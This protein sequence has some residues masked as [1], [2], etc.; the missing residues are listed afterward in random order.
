[1]PTIEKPVELAQALEKLAALQIELQSAVEAVS[2][3]NVTIETLT[4]ENADLKNSVTEKENEFT[5][6]LNTVK[7][8]KVLAE[9]SLADST[10]AVHLLTDMLKESND[11]FTLAEEKIVAFEE[12][13]ATA[14]QEKEDLQTQN[15]LIADQLQIRSVAP[16]IEDFVTGKDAQPKLS[17]YATAYFGAKSPE[18]KLNARRAYNSNPVLKAEID[19]ELDKRTKSTPKANPTKVKVSAEDQAL[20]DKWQED[21]REANAVLAQFSAIPPKQRA[22]RH[23][24]LKVAN[25]KF[26]NANKPAI[27]RVLNSLDSRSATA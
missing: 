7:A 20:Y 15:D 8:E 5:E 6:Q 25:R 9:N 2:T 23:S 4:Q 22:V 19:G 17:A 13:A 18:D 1:M 11:A 16:D 26:Y 3:A 12:V 10:N 21:E 24:E 14:L 27:D